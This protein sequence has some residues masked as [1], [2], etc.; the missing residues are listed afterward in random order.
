MKIKLQTAAILF[1]ILSISISSCVPAGTTTAPDMPTALGETTSPPPVELTS[2]TLPPPTAEPTA[3]VYPPVFDPEVLGDSRE[4]ASF[5]STETNRRTES[6]VVMVD[7]SDSFEYIKEP[8]SMHWSGGDMYVIGS[9]LYERINARLGWHYQAVTDQQDVLEW[10]AV[11]T[12]TVY[13][14]NLETAQFL[15]QEDFK[16]I[17][18][19]HFSFDLTNYRVTSPPRPED[20]EFAR[21]TVQGDFYLSQV[22]SYLLFY[23]VIEKGILYEPYRTAQYVAVQENKYEL[24]MINQLAEISLPANFDLEL[25]FGLPL[26]AGTTLNEI[27]SYRDGFSPD[28]YYYT[29]LVNNDEFLEFYKNLAPANGFTF[30]RIGTVPNNINCDSQ[31]CVILNMGSIEILLTFVSGTTSNSLVAQVYR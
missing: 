16:G 27:V 4:L 2:A 10:Q 31:D 19:N 22:G 20:W 9:R 15:G 24:S 26:P 5:S 18:A 25:D 21:D 8:F 17:P 30:S 14:S 1:F 6:G 7:K 3:T 12:P 11:L 28:S 23:Q 13:L 29:L